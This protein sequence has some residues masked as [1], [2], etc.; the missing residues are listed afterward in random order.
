MYRHHGFVGGIR[1]QLNTALMSRFVIL[2]NLRWNAM[3]HVFPLRRET[4]EE[5]DYHATHDNRDEL[6]N[7]E[8]IHCP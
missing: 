1:W 6:I 7:I 8:E 4:D 5:S 3:L 2:Y